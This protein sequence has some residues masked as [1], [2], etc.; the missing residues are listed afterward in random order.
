MSNGKSK[1]RNGHSYYTGPVAVRL[2][3]NLLRD[4]RTSEGSDFFAG[5]EQDLLSDISKFRSRKEKDFEICSV[6]KFKRTQ[7][8]EALLKKFRFSTDNYTDDELSEKTLN[9]FLEEQVRLHT[10]MPLKLSGHIV[11][12]RARV[13]AKRILGTYPGDEVIDNVRFGKKSSI[14]CPFSLAYIDIKLS[15][16]R[17]FTGTCAT[18]KFFFDQVLPGD[19]ILQRILGYLDEGKLEKQLSL[20]H[21]NLVEVPKTWKSYRLITPLTLLGLFFSYGYARVV[22]RRLKNAGLDIAKLQS[23]HRSLVKG[24]SRSCS[25]ATADLSCASDSLTS[26]LLNRILP[27]PWYVALKKTF[28]RNLRVGDT[29]Y[30]TASVLPMGNGATFPVETLVFYCLI[31]AIGELTD[32]KGVYSVYG[33]DLIYPSDLHKFVSGVFP[34]LH[35][36]LN[37][38]KT[39]VNLPFRESCGSDFYRGQ[40]VRPYFLRGEAQCLTRVRY[41]AFLYKVYN[42]LT[43]RWD[44]LEIKE[45]LTWVLS[46]LAMVSHGILRVPPSY[47]D[48]SGVKVSSSADIPLSFTLLPFSPVD[49]RFI[50]GSQDF[51]FDFLTETPKKRIVKTTQPFYWLALQGITD[52]VIVDEYKQEVVEPVVCEDDEFLQAALTRRTVRA[53]REGRLPLEIPAE[54]RR[55]SL[56]W[57]KLARKTGKIYYH[58]GRKVEKKRTTYTAV[59]DSKQGSTVSTATTK[60]GS[61]TFWA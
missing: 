51:Q 6:S 23:R 1:K 57:N 25:H 47:P 60:T 13:I 14:G 4:F 48:Y 28:V 34:Q 41:E 42:G 45:T 59:V 22:T 31:K 50:N 39:F 20:T 52:D 56:K 9:T 36:K 26:E 46:E 10:P 7:Q 43:A 15:M 11:L 2:Y 21:L 58:H 61:I 30:S 5:A 16:K 12:Q 35:L 33:D 38:D 53:I 44:P 55:S 49:C 32:L 3:S 27:R 18:S 40:D 8:L 17:A 24:F 19:H 37:Q 54:Q 29:V